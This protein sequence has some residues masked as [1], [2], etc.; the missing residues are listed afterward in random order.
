MSQRDILGLVYSYVYAF[1]LLGIVEGAGRLFKW[2]HHLTRKFIHIGAGLWVWGILFFFD[3]WEYGII[4][5]ATFIVLN[6]IFYRFKIFQTMDDPEATPGTVY[7]AISITILMVALWRKDGPVDYVPAA[8]AGIMAMTIGDAMASIVGKINGKHTYRV[9]G[10]MRSYEGTWMMFLFSLFAILLTMMFLP[11]SALSPFS[12]H[13][14]ATALMVTVLIATLVATAAEAF[15]PAGTDNLSVPLLT[16][17][18]L[19]L[20][21]IAG[22]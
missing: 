9:F 18:V 21:M 13:M 22:K 17:G 3:H 14:N 19:Y 10:H 12:P 8:V 5:F 20:L 11:G 1:A 4:P 7:F 2:P 16:G 15:S 6:F